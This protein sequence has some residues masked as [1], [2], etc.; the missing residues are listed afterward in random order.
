M[1]P[2][3]NWERGKIVKNG[4]KGKFGQKGNFRL[5]GKKKEKTGK[6]SYIWKRGE[7]RKNR[8]IVCV[9]VKDRERL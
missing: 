1:V 3:E 7:M 6:M 9:C 2:W 8:D 4:E 5:N